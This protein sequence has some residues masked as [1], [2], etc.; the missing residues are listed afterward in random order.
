MVKESQ[1]QKG[2][3]PCDLLKILVQKIGKKTVDMILEEAEQDK[4]DFKVSEF[5]RKPKNE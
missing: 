2:D 4:S 5:D 3:D 1:E